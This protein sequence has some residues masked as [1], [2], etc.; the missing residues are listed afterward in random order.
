MFPRK[1]N[2]EKSFDGILADEVVATTTTSSSSSSPSSSGMEGVDQRVSAATVDTTSPRS[3]AAEEGVGAITTSPS[4]SGME[5]VNQRVSAA[6]VDTTSPRPSAAAKGVGAV[7]ASGASGGGAGQSR[8]RGGGRGRGGRTAGGGGDVREARLRDD[9]TKVAGGGG[10]DRL[11]TEVHLEN[12]KYPPF[13]EE[14]IRKCSR[15]ED[16]VRTRTIECD[17]LKE[18]KTDLQRLQDRLPYEVHACYICAS[19]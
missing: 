18:D 6:T 9:T 14:L 12:E 7:G 10:D 13:V 16:E 11:C 5:G 1:I 15:L 17:N 3:L 4:S 8:G 2:E 19:I